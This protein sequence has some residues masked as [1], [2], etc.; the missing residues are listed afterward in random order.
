MYSIVGL[1]PI[2]SE[3]FA[4]LHKSGVGHETD[5]R[6]SQTYFIPTGP[7]ARGRPEAVG[8]WPK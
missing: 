4:A 5:I 2:K 3:G 6:V 7:S 1:K 8:R